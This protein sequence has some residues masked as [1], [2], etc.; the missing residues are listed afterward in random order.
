MEEEEWY[1]MDKMIYHSSVVAMDF[2]EELE[3]QNAGNFYQGKSTL[4]MLGIGA[5]D[6]R[7][8]VMV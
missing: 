4:K 2:K 6:Y 1:F 5:L 8:I 7:S 3:H